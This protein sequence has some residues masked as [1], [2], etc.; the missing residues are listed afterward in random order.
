[1]V[2]SL[3][4]FFSAGSTVKS[5]IRD[6]QETRALWKIFEGSRQ[7]KR[8]CGRGSKKCFLCVW[9]RANWDW[10]LSNRSELIQNEEGPLEDIGKNQNKGNWETSKPIKGKTNLVFADMLQM[11]SRP[12]R[13][14]CG[15]QASFR[16]LEKCLVFLLCSAACVG[17]SVRREKHLR[18]H[19]HC[20]SQ[21][22]RKYSRLTLSLRIA[23]PS[24]G[25]STW[26]VH[27]G[28]PVSP[29]FTC[30]LSGVA[31]IDSPAEV[32]RGSCSSISV[33]PGPAR[34]ELTVPNRHMPGH[35]K[36]HSRADSAFTWTQT[37]P[38][39]SFCSLAGG[40]SIHRKKSLCM[41]TYNV[42]LFS[43]WTQS[44]L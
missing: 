8:L 6:L 25:R 34:S 37:A 28:W 32:R 9:K 13:T 38:T 24:Q 1:M 44:V 22:H 21:R 35:G 33:S 4:F 29:K 20:F 26:K 36:Q 23:C 12:R 2:N 15:A 31:E 40:K 14:R 5:F 42:D 10:T 11:D 16:K 27:S 30:I 17:T 7:P 3:R 43:K 18:K 39:A 19:H 41:D